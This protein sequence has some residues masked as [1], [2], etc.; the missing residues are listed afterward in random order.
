MDT[1]TS[2][3]INESPGVRSVAFKLPAVSSGWRSAQQ[4][5][6]KFN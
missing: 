5:L 6:F 1:F 4:K 3:N 2:E